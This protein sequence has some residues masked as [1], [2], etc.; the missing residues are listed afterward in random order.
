[1]TH[2]GCASRCWRFYRI[3]RTVAVAA[4]S[5]PAR[6]CRLRR[7]GGGVEGTCRA[8]R[9]V[10]DPGRGDACG[11]SVVAFAEGRAGRAGRAGRPVRGRGGA[12][13]ARR[14][15]CRSVGP[16][17]DPDLGRR[18]CDRGARRSRPRRGM[19]GGAVGDRSG[20]GAGF[21]E[22][23]PTLEAKVW[24]AV[25]L[26]RLAG[27]VAETRAIDD[28]L[29]RPRVEVAGLDA[30]L[31]AAIVH[32]YA[33][34]CE[35]QSDPRWRIEALCTDP[36]PPIDQD[37]H[38]AR[39]A[40]ALTAAGF[41]PEPPVYCGDDWGRAPHRGPHRPASRSRPASAT[42]PGRPHRR[43]ARAP[44][45]SPA[46]VHRF[47]GRRDGIPPRPQGVAGHRVSPPQRA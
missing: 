2:R 32:Q 24:A 15:F 28:A 42:T 29:G 46:S 30:E 41:D 43:C 45:R 36:P 37:A 39:A 14:S 22:A 4:A 47:P 10:G 1:M 3:G 13:R 25:A 31:R 9:P 17:L 27:D 23:A 6:G 35:R 16:G 26:H 38:L 44:C 11:R 20:P 19:S 34:T 7:A 40:A 21:L 33:P 18:R 12:G 8:R 5:G